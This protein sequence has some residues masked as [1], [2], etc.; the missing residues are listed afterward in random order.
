MIREMQYH[1]LAVVDTM[2]PLPNF[3]TEDARVLMLM[4]LMDGLR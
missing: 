2:L 4:I 3:L 1:G